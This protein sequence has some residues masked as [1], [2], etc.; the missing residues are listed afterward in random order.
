MHKI[1]S[2]F[3][4]MGYNHQPKNLFDT[5]FRSDGFPQE[6][7]SYMH[8]HQTTDSYTQC[9]HTHT[10]VST[11]SVGL[12]FHGNLEDYRRGWTMRNRTIMTRWLAISPAIIITTWAMDSRFT[13]S[14]AY[15]RVGGLGLG[16]GGWVNHDETISC[17][18]LCGLE[19]LTLICWVLL[20]NRTFPL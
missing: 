10:H 7:V 12:V 15:R 16:P 13:R 17:N 9:A 1:S 2:H 6:M 20:G 5:K 19:P 11:P 4:G 3:F 8:S 14:K 18:K